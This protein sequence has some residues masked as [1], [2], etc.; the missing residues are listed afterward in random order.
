[1]F[2]SDKKKYHQWYDFFFQF[3]FSDNH[4]QPE[5]SNKWQQVIYKTQLGKKIIPLGIKSYHKLP[6]FTPAFLQYWV[7]WN[8]FALVCKASQPTVLR[9]FV[10]RALCTGICQTKSNTSSGMI[11]SS[12]SV[13]VTTT[14]N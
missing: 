1:M 12:S 13:S 11:F 8:S 14:H 5:T 4:T 3:S 7:F 2:L 9:L 10:I 6:F